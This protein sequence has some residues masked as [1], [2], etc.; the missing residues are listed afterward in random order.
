MRVISGKYRGRVLN[1]PKDN[2]VRPTTDMVKESLFNIIQTDVQDA[3]FLDLFAGSGS[4]GIEAISRGAAEV[5]FC[6][7]DRKSLE[8][9]KSN[10][11]L[12]NESAKIIEG[13]YVSSLNRLFGEK[14]D[15]IFVDPPYNKGY[16]A[17]IINRLS[18]YLCDDGIVIVESKYSVVKEFVDKIT[19]L[20]LNKT[21]KYGGSALTI[22][23]KLIEE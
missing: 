13:D 15:I 14:F 22:F 20:S 4:I 11:N 17:D 12:I 23:K 16:E 6:D 21:R 19:A 3:K 8:I 10:L 7:N 5:I 1:S 18:D 9:V 2:A